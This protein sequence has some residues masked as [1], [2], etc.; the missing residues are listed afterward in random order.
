MNLN[1]GVEIM[2]AINELKDE[3]VQDYRD[4]FQGMIGN[5]MRENI[6]LAV[7]QICELYEKLDEMALEKLS[8][9]Q[10]V[11]IKQLQRQKLLN[12][13]VS[14][15]LAGKL[16]DELELTD[17][18]MTVLKKKEIETKEWEKNEI[19][20]IR[21]EA[22]EKIISSLPEDLTK[23]LKEL[24]GK[25]FEFTEDTSRASSGV[26]FGRGAVRRQKRNWILPPVDTS[27]IREFQLT[28]NRK[29]AIW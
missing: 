23:Q 28:K 2:D 20:R 25:K 13:G 10:I 16:G 29:F 26:G 19:A 8:N 3:M 22:Q 4:A 15:A 5:G 18:Q 6:K 11:R 21:A 12:I 7:D 9:D 14:K 27:S 24:T 1:V 17:D